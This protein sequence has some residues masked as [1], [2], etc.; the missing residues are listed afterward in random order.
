MG[1]SWAG[2]SSGDSSAGMMAGGRDMAQ[3]ILSP[4][5]SGSKNQSPMNRRSLSL[6]RPPHSDPFFVLS[7]LEGAAEAEESGLDGLDGQKTHGMSQAG[8][9]TS[10]TTGWARLLGALVAFFSSRR[11]WRRTM[12]SLL[13]FLCLSLLTFKVY[14][15]IVLTEDLHRPAYFFKVCPCFQICVLVTAVHLFLSLATGKL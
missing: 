5:F 2:A 7:Y 6:K 11:G 13:L 15:G 12:F 3:V 4:R 10:L 8:V 14:T 9:S 1:S